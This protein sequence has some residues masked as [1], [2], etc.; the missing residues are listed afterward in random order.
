MNI[1]YIK[2]NIHCE[3][4]IKSK[5]KTLIYELQILKI[6]KITND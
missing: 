1:K 2:K 3:I 4:S 6:L 5:I